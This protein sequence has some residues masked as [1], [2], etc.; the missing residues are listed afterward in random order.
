[1]LNQMQ[2]IGYLGNDPEVRYLPTGEAVANFSVATTEKWKDKNTLQT[3]EHTEWIRVSFFGRK[4]EVIKEYVHKGSLVYVSGK[5]K[6]RKWTDQSGVDRYST[7]VQGQ[8]FK[9][10]RNPSQKQDDEF[11]V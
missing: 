2:V 6:T 3:V 10:L 8:E 9:I 1:M 11:P 7:D 5:W 4:A